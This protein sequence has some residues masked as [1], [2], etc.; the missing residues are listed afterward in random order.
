MTLR[1]GGGGWEGGG[2]HGI[3]WHASPG[4]RIEYIATDDRRETIPWVRVVSGRGEV[5]EYVGEG[6][7]PEQIATAERRVMDCTDCH[8]RQGH[9]IA[10]TPDRAVDEALAR[11]LLPRLPFVRREAIAVLTDPARDAAQAD[12]EITERL[13]AFYASHAIEGQQVSQAIAATRQ[14]YATNVFPEMRVGW[15]T[16]PNQQGHTDFPGCFRCHDE[17]KQTAT[18]LVLSQDCESCHRQQ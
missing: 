1:V 2:P 6:I 11:G 12:R 5:R 3:H 13:T 18:G 4:T 16:Y 17:T 8:N 7:T 10:A 9:P 14:L 15:G